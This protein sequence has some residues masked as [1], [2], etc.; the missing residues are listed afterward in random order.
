MR[1]L[2]CFKP[3]MRNESEGVGFVLAPRW[4]SLSSKRERR[5]HRPTN[6][7]RVSGL[8]KSISVGTRKMV[9]YA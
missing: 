6:R 2:G 4:E 1:V 5:H 9:N 7:L 8:R 3:S